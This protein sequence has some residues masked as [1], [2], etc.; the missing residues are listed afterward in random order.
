MKISIL[1]ACLLLPILT[2][3]AAQSKK[4]S[5]SSASTAK[6]GTSFKLDG[7]TLRGKY[8]TSLGTNA[9]VEND[10]YLD[11]LLGGRKSFK[12]RIQEDQNRN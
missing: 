8:Q 4:V 1:M 7:S 5:P 6:L 12:D 9:T 3:N 11:D 10:K 2:A